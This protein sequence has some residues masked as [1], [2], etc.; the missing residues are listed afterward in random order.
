M[1]EMPREI[2]H[3]HWSQFLAGGCTLLGGPLHGKYVMLSEFG[4]NGPY[5]KIR[6]AY[7]P[8]PI[9]KY[10][11]GRPDH[12]LDLARPHIAEYEAH[13]I[14]Q[15]AQGLSLV[16]FVYRWSGLHG[17]QVAPLAFALLIAV[18]MGTVDLSSEERRYTAPAG[19]Q[20]EPC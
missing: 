8:E 3:V 11:H 20:V 15:A 18:N 4:G 16:G 10:A 19:H 12:P 2:N 14:R 13:E 7:M 1:L 17:S 9:P 6:L 5:P